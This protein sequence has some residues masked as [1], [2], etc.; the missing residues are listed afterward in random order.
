MMT[1]GEKKL[2]ERYLR[3]K[4]RL[5][6]LGGRVLLKQCLLRSI[7][8]DFCQSVD[9]KDIDIKRGEN[10]K[11]RLFI[12]DKEIDS[13]HFS[14][15]HKLNYIFCAV[16][17]D[18]NIGIDVEKVDSKLIRLKSYYMSPDEEKI[19][20]GTIKVKALLP[21]YYTMLWASKE[22]LVKCLGQNLWQVLGNSE[23][24]EIRGKEY[25]LR[26]R[27]EDREIKVIS[28]NYLYD[29]YIFSVMVLNV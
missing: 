20:F 1:D 6:F 16:D 24:V 12:H 5:E 8:K 2:Y 22:C 23:L 10:G 27:L 21:A 7:N 13:V 4:S 29:G 25:V 28:R 26:Y 15:S 17:N 9:F 19:I 14:I 11:P 18:S 3:E